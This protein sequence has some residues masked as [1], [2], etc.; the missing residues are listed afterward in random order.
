L[1]HQALG[2]HN[3][4]R[5]WIGH[6]LYTL[7]Y[8]KYRYYIILSFKKYITLFLSLPA[9]PFQPKI[10]SKDV[11][12]ENGEVARVMLGMVW[13]SIEIFIFI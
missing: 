1:Q 11:S 6:Q 4:A 2:A 8:K 3:D 7:N 13:L 10:K 12:V 9:Y 5:L